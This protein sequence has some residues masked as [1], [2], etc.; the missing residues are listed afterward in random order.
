VYATHGAGS[1]LIKLLQAHG[2]QLQRPRG[3]H[4]RFVHP[5]KPGTVT[6]PRP[7]KDL[8]KGLSRAIRK[9]AGLSMRYPIAIETG[10]SKHAY[11]V[12]VPDLP[13][14]FSAWTWAI[15]DVDVSEL[16][17]KAARINITL[18]QRILRA[19]D[20]HVRKQ[21]ETL[22]EAAARALSG[23]WGSGKRGEP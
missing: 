9:Q 23:I 10:D 6:V 14:C 15:V 1:A 22:A 4:H 2:W 8:G 16:G 7:K 17:D 5:M 18:P 21:G 3:S 20:S 13:G 11:G 12:V 19:V